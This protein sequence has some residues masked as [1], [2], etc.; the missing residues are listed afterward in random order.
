MRAAMSS[1]LFDAAHLHEPIFSWLAYL[2]QD[3]VEDEVNDYINELR[4]GSSAFFDELD[5]HEL[6]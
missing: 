4:A 3:G 6:I 2:E 5:K 1:V